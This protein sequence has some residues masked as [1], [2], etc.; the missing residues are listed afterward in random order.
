MVYTVINHSSS[1]SDDDR[2]DIDGDGEQTSSQSSK[3]GIGFWNLD[4]ELQA[5]KTILTPSSDWSPRVYSVCKPE[6][7]HHTTT[8]AI[9]ERLQT[10]MDGS[11]S[12]EL[13]TLD[14]VLSDS[15]LSPSIRQTF[16]ETLDGSIAVVASQGDYDLLVQGLTSLAKTRHLYQA[17]HKAANELLDSSTPTDLIKQVTSQ[18]GESLFRIDDDDDFLS[19][20]TIGRSYN[21]SAE[22][23]FCR[24]VNG[25]FAETKIK[26]GFKEFDETTGGF[27]RTNLVIIGGNSGGGKCTYFQALIPT[28]QG[29]LQIG[30]I[31]NLYANSNDTGWIKIPEGS[32]K[33][34][35][36]E[37]IKDVDGVYKTEG[38]TYKIETKW[39]DEFEGLGEHKL[40]CYDNEAQTFGF[41][42]LDDIQVDRD[43]ILKTVGTNI[44]GTNLAIPYAPPILDQNSHRHE[45]VLYYPENLTDNLATLFGL[46]VAE[47][48]K[49]ISFVNKDPQILTYVITSLR[50]HFGCEQK[51]AQDG[52]TINFNEIITN[53]V[54]HFCGDVKSSERFIPKCIMQAPASIQYAFLRGL[55]E[56]DGC[57][58][59][60]NKCGKMGKNSNVWSLEYSSISK[61]LIYDLKGLLEN[62]GIY[63]SIRT[64]DTC[65]S[66]GSE[67]QVS[68]DGYT[69]HILRESFEDF[70]QKIG[71]M[72]ERKSLELAKCVTTYNKVKRDIN[73]SVCGYYNRIPISPVR[74]YIHRV[75]ELMENQTIE[76][77][78]GNHW[79]DTLVTYAKPIGKYYIFYPNS[80]VTNTLTTMDNYISKYT[81]QRITT[82]HFGVSG[83]SKRTKELMPIIP[84]I[85]NL[86]ENDPILIDLR[87]Q[88]NEL[89]SQVWAQ[90]TSVEKKE[91]IVP[92]FDLSVPSLHEYAANGLMSHNS[93]LA[94]NLL[95]RQFRLGYN[96]TLVSY[97]MTDDE[98]LIR[99]L[100]N[101]SEVDMN[102]LQNN[103]LL[104]NETNR[105]TAAWREFNLKGYEKENS[106]N[107]IC[108]KMETTV[109]EIGFR[110]RSLKPDVLILDYINLLTSSSGSDEAQWQSLG[111]ISRDAKLLANKLNC[112]VI[113]LAQIDDTY[114]LRYS[115]GI[116]DHANFVWGFIRDDSARNSRIINIKQLKARNAPLYDFE[117]AERFDIAQFRD[118][119]QVDRTTWP[120]DDELLMMEIQCQSL[121][122]K[123]EPTVS[124]EFDRKQR[125][126][127]RQLV[128]TNIGKN[129]VHDEKIG[130]TNIE[131]QSVATASLLFSDDAIPID[132][133][134][135]AVKS[136]ETSLLKTDTTTLY[137]DTV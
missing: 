102:R 117:L 87:S 64:K 42:R 3:S 105:V 128:N 10:L 11:K 8:K 133:T 89:C 56:G 98:V 44:Y 18:L 58:Y 50:N 132:F 16:R 122:L 37:G 103:R 66:N 20:L 22:D 33:V 100:S 84:E 6:F 54:I 118:E 90:V 112:V 107:I 119:G 114:N 26:S 2:P 123:L 19:Q 38:S 97:E 70:Q 68:K 79:N 91:E 85:R 36:R 88:I 59:E 5:I 113:L 92:V 135:L 106:Y 49:A 121:G 21:Q 93:L 96:T 131:Q 41:K 125:L 124:K 12:F 71:F 115:K 75:F 99:L 108:P 61:R 47:G 130:N 45:D 111:N 134:K 23:A 9:F 35:T 120:T 63:C 116:K 52:H 86:I 15:K 51:I 46:I 82:S 78:Q 4:L 83:R 13:P 80:F 27:H 76:V 40:Y 137:E 67:N 34:Y 25:S 32:L 60:V 24:I 65:A 39:K 48:H 136:N 94:V 77:T 43:W 126:E 69:L 7:F 129:C 72:S 31:Y 104:P 28:N 127:A 57:I 74:A 29:I 14:F 1:S 101:I 30:N 55:Y 17:T 81:A 62:I 95:E 53:Y 109:P 110:V 73:R